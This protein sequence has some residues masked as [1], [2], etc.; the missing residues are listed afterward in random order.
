MAVITNPLLQALRTQLNADFKRGFESAEPNHMP[1]TMKVPSTSAS[2]TY[3]WIGKMASVRKWVGDRIINDLAEHGYTIFNDKFEL[4]HG[5]DRTDIED[6]NLGIYSTL[7]EDIGS[8]M[9]KHEG[10]MVYEQVQAGFTTPC[11]DG[12][13]F[14]DV[15]HPVNAKHDGTGAVTSVSNI[16]AGTGTNEPWY[17]IDGSRTL[18]P[19]IY[20][21]RKKPVFTAMTKMDDEAVFTSDKFRYG[22][23]KRGGVG[24]GLWQQMIASKEVLNE[25]NF[26]NAC[27]Q[28]ANFKADGG[29]PL[30]LNPTI[31]LVGTS[32]RAAAEKLLN[33]KVLAS[34]ESN[35]LYKKATIV[36]TPYL[37]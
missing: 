21:E 12:Q 26:T 4:T 33:T 19:I 20:Q 8:E 10:E 25:T 35:V 18:K 2:N 32:N 34:G 13:Y 1:I 23:D 9:A 5:V 36:Y 28:M 15:D 31:L 29:K 17:V 16:Q 6:D 11:Y 7:F 24:F 27:T 14:F 30:G 37:P 3:G 22:S